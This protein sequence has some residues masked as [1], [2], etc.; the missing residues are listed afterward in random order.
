MAETVACKRI[1]DYLYNNL[2]NHRT[3]PVEDHF[4]FTYGVY[5]TPT[6]SVDQDIIMFM[7]SQMALTAKQDCFAAYAIVKEDIERAD[8]ERGYYP[9][10][11]KELFRIAVQN[12]DFVWGKDKQPHKIDPEV[13]FMIKH[14]SKKDCVRLMPK[15]LTDLTWS[16]RKPIILGKDHFKEC[17]ECRSCKERK[18][19]YD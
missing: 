17:G 14:L 19:A 18:A 15:E 3:G 5:R 13:K 9:W 12:G 10:V 8:E 2:P 1:V 7:L 6:V 4:V 16:C 11:G